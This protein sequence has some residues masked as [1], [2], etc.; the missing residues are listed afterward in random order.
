[1]RSSCIISVLPAVESDQSARKGSQEHEQSAVLQNVL[2]VDTVQEHS[3][4][5]MGSVYFNAY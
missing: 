2:H 1:M 5:L 3:G 4:A